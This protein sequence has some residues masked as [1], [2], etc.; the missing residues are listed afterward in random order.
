MDLNK[1]EISLSNTLWGC[2]F[3]FFSLHSNNFFSIF[4][5]LFICFLLF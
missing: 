4:S 5:C 3:L 1:Y 2:F